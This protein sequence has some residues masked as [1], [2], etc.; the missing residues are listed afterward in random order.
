MTTSATLYNVERHEQA[1]FVRQF[2]VAAAGVV[3]WIV[4]REPGVSAAPF[5]PILT[6]VVL[7]V[8]Y[9]TMAARRVFYPAVK[10]IQI[11][12]DLLLWTWLI[13]LTGGYAS[14]FYPIYAFEIMLSSITLSVAGCVYAAALSC[15]LYSS[16]IVLDPGSFAPALLMPR[17][18]L[19][20][21]TAVV[22]VA[23]I[24]KLRRNEL[25][26]SRLN[27]Q[28]K[29]DV[30]VAVTQEDA[31]VTNMTSG[32]IGVDA[33]G[34]ITIFNRSA[35]GITGLKRDE[36]LGV[37]C[38]EA[39]GKNPIC[40]KIM[41]SLGRGCPPD[42]V[43]MEVE[44]APGGPARRIAM[45][46]FVMPVGFPTRCVCV[47]QDRTELRD[48]E[49]RTTRAETLSNLGTVAATL[50]HEL[51]TPLTAIAGFASMLRERLAGAPQEAEMAEKIERGVA[52]LA[53][54][55]RQLLDF[56]ETPN[57]SRRRLDLTNVIG[58]TMEL[59]PE[60]MRSEIK[61][62]FN[63]ED[64]PLHVDGDPLQLRQAFLNLLLNAC[65]AAGPGGEVEVELSSRDGR[66]FLEVSDSGPGVPEHLRSKI[67]LPFVTTKKG[68]TG[69]GLAHSEK[70]IRAHGGRLTLASPEDGGAVFTVMLPRA[71]AK[72]GEDACCGADSLPKT[73][74]HV[75]RSGR[76][77]AAGAGL[78]RRRAR[79]TNTGTHMP[80]DEAG[81]TRNAQTLEADKT[82]SC[83]AHEEAGSATTAAIPFKGRHR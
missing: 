80:V 76:Q 13:R 1:F 14:V 63:N 34:G 72:I 78:A 8:L 61:V 67:F 55:T 31:I 29:R 23:L 38:S 22:C 53:T 3:Y 50:A 75:E 81:A 45:S 25:I 57:L 39:L 52:S 20:A 28:L 70:L 65:D 71:D 10:W 17:L 44:F 4:S 60:R 79:R 51:R 41:G 77:T 12:V 46:C 42:E 83:K 73:K 32:L 16:G 64:A 18:A 48:L 54:V 7:N 47:I 69:L 59:V 56:T 15:I 6:A 37:G 24:R 36:V 58:S 43:E 62:S 35:E 21:G 74:D 82:A 11:P 40:R 9:Y 2:L 49:Q 19:F 5:I 68:G 33:N 26:V 27:E 30:H 66:V